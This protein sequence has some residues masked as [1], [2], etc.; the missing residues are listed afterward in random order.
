MLKGKEKERKAHSSSPHD[1]LLI[2]IQRL[3]NFAWYFHPFIQLSLIVGYGH[4]K[5]DRQWRWMMD[6]RWARKAIKWSFYRRIQVCKHQKRLEIEQT[7]RKLP[8]TKKRGDHGL[9]IE[10]PMEH[11]N[12]YNQEMVPSVMLVFSCN[13]LDCDIDQDML[14]LCV[15]WPSLLP[16]LVYEV[17][18]SSFYSYALV[19]W[20]WNM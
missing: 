15:F 6:D 3:S 20:S 2:H 7:W 9:T 4:G 14:V 1:K 8:N 12:H 5:D 13:L 18:K 17:S 16:C 19:L 11:G 10:G